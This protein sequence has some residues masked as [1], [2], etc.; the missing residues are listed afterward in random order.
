MNPA[1]KSLLTAD[2]FM[3]WAV[4]LPEGERYIVGNH[5][6]QWK[7]SVLTTLPC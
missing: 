6:L 1:D 4:D 3:Q 2:V 7:P 5:F